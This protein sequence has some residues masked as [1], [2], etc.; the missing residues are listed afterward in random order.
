MNSTEMPDGETGFGPIATTLMQAR[1]L[2]TPET[3]VQGMGVFSGGGRY[4][5]MTA[6]G[7]ASGTATGHYPLFISSRNFFYTATGIK[8]GSEWND[9]HTYAEVMEG[10]DKAIALAI[11]EGV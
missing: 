9:T 11:Q 4:C 7:K 2:L 8:S 1:A 5:V 3:W 10:F 6:L